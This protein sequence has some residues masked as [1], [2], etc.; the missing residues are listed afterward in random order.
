MGM[1]IFLVSLVCGVSV[2]KWLPADWI[3]DLIE[4]STA[5]KIAW[6]AIKAIGFFI[7][8]ACGK[9]FLILCAALLLYYMLTKK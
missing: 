8:F 6:V 1:L 9:I 7:G 3:Y 4:K 2:A 5:A